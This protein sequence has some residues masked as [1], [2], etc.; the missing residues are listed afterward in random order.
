[1]KR[2]E[3]GGENAKTPSA[4][5]F[6]GYNDSNN[7]RNRLCCQTPVHKHTSK[8]LTLYINLGHNTPLNLHN[9]SV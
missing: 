2:G 5:M 7:Q 1:M 4:R 3:S 9:A 8:Y 6:Q